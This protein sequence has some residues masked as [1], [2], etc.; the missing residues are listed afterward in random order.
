VLGGA[1]PDGELAAA[2]GDVP[3]VCVGRSFPDE[4]AHGIL[5]E[6]REAARVVVEH[7][8]GLGH[9]RIA[10]IT[11][12]PVMTDARARLAGYLDALRG[13]GLAPDA[14]LVVE[15]GFLV[16]GGARGVEEL[17][18]RG[19]EFTGLF[20]ANDVMAPSALLALARHGLDVPRDVSVVGFDDEEHSAWLRP[21]LTT[22]RQHL[23]EIGWMAAEGAL[24]LIDGKEVGL[25]VSSPE[26]VVR[27]STAPPP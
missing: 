18:A 17:V 13:A 26:L 1:L 7:L 14:A 11:G 2:A 10:H 16:D 21:P 25:P 27:E 15:G 8:I 3:L 20:V 19:V 23:F 9:R 22:M 5:V 12:D 4:R 6:N 24:R